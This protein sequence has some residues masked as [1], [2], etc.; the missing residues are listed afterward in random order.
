[1]YTD[2]ILVEENRKIKI[3]HSKKY[4][5]WL[6]E[7]TDAQPNCA[8]DDEAIEFSPYF[9][10]YDKKYAALFSIFQTELEKLAKEQFVISL[11]TNKYEYIKYH[12][13][14]RGNYYETVILD[15][16]GRISTIKKI[17]TPCENFIYVDEKIPPEIKKERE[18]IEFIII[19]KDIN[20][21]DPQYA[22][23]IAHVC[24]NA[25]LSQS[26]EE[27]FKIWY[28]NGK[29]Q[30]KIILK[31]SENILLELED[32]FFATHDIGHNDIP[33]NALIAVSLGILS[34]KEAKKY[35]EHCELWK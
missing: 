6:V 20:I 5:E 2:N 12:F 32:K 22:V 27:K 15:G 1:M 31:A 21:T 26:K 29:N 9:S 3:V 17:T 19:N 14:L 13:K 16:N 23:H 4:L 7:F 25:A 11:N 35:I 33:Q 30:K 24:T 18:L 10:N 34:R 28:Q 8:W